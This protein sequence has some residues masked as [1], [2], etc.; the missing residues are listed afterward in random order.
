MEL[1]AGGDIDAI[2][3]L[4]VGGDIGGDRLAVDDDR[5]RRTRAGD[6]RRDPFELRL[7]LVLVAVIAAVVARRL[8]IPSALMT[9]TVVAI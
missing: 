9:V 1:L 4:E 7:R 3:A 2:P 5:Q 8:G 6:A